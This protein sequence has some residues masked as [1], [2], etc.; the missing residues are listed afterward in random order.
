MANT[1]T[2]SNVENGL[3]FDELLGRLLA[4]KPEQWGFTEQDYNEIATDFTV[5]SNDLWYLP[6]G[7]YK[8]TNLPNSPFNSSFVN[9]T[10]FEL[11]S[12]KKF[13]TCDIG[14]IEKYSLELSAAGS[15]I[16][17]V[18]IS[19]KQRT[20]VDAVIFHIGVNAPTDTTMMWVDTS[21]LSTD[22]SIYLKYY[23]GTKWVSYSFNDIMLQ[24]I[25][26]RNKLNKDPYE[27]VMSAI[28]DFTIKYGEF[29]RHANNE[30]T[31][32]HISAED[33]EFY[34][35]YLLTST[36]IADYFA[37]DGE[38]Y[39][40]LVAYTN[41]KTVEV[42]GIDLDKSDSEINGTNGLD[43]KVTDHINGTA[44]SPHISDP[45]M[46]YWD[47]KS[48]KD[49]PHQS[50]GRV[51]ITSSNIVTSSESKTFT[52]DQ[53]T[54]EAQERPY[55]ISNINVLATK[56]STSDLTNK[57]H[58]GNT[59]YIDNPDG[60][61]NWWKIID[62]TKFGTADYLMGVKAITTKTEPTKFNEIKNLPNTYSGY[63]ITDAVSKNLV[64]YAN[65]AIYS[66]IIPEKYSSANVGTNDL[67]VGIHR[68]MSSTGGGNTEN[69][70]S[71]D[72]SDLD[73]IAAIDNTSNLDVPTDKFSCLA[74]TAFRFK[75]TSIPF[76]DKNWNEVCYGNGVYVAAGAAKYFVYSLDGITW[77]QSKSNSTSRIWRGI[78]YGNGMFIA[79]SGDGY[80]AYSSDGIT[81]KEKNIATNTNLLSVCYGNGKYIALSATIFYYSSNGTDWVQCNTAMTGA[82][83]TS[84]CYGN[85]RYVAITSGNKIFAHS[86]DGITWTEGNI[87]DAYIPWNSVCY[88]NGKFVIVAANS[89]KFAHSTDGITWTESTMTAT[90]RNW[91]GVCYGNGKFVAV[92][93]NGNVFAHSTDGITWTEGTIGDTSKNWYSVCYGN[94]KFVAISYNS[95]FAYISEYYTLPGMSLYQTDIPAH[96]YFST[97]SDTDIDNSEWENSGLGR[98]LKVDTSILNTVID[99]VYEINGSTYNVNILWDPDRGLIFKHRI[100]NSIKN[101]N[102]M[103]ANLTES[104]VGLTSFIDA[105]KSA[106][107]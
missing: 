87:S 38:L 56:P 64:D 97:L 47:S 80:V 40:E 6:A 85:G 100:D 62:N 65:S 18:D 20:G 34:N 67:Y 36:F 68:T 55:P 102:T 15:S 28:S 26:D 91:S 81:W 13:Y 77:N 30:L 76:I 69:P 61:T 75:E 95:A 23:N 49:H 7:N 107:I 33:R 21:K 92:L 82:N 89:N 58:N 83:W 9:I 42:I 60:T 59:L 70:M 17:W 106:V 73:I 72:Y 11:A 48:D 54:T 94:D 63:G 1:Y 12:N 8:I 10:V 84:V 32:I 90:V 4:F 5:S 101:A 3:T 51:K 37:K 98:M 57:Y 41:S 71:T 96:N 39:N 19:N 46:R 29:T 16:N 53:I 103:L 78:C 86:T 22:D 93:T 74:D 45:D 66:E 27:A 99:E 88:G 25:Y 105:L 50:D 43:K 44:N 31:L 104:Y 14:G 79:V 52:I 24:D 35:N 2:S